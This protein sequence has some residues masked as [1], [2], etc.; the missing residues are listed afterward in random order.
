M[1]KYLAD[2]S[3]L[4]AFFNKEDANYSKARNMV[5]EMRN[6]Y[7]IVPSVVVAELSSFNKNVDLREL[8]IEN[9][10]STASEVSSFGDRDI[11]A[12][13]TFRRYYQDNLTTI[14]S[15]ILFSAIDRG[16]ILLTL[17]KELKKK[18]EMVCE[19]LF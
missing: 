11:M 9:A 4:S 8:L 17:D 16:A 1:N 3:F 19:N 10:I 15:I 6:E 5:R 7:L 12:Y 18:Y 13:L 2:T 14:D